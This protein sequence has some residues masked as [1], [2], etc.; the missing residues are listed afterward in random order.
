MQPVQAEV[1][2][3]GDARCEVGMVAGKQ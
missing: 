1:F 3:G 2:N